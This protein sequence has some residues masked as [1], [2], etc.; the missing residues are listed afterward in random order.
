[1]DSSLPLPTC[2][3]KHSLMS[4]RIITEKKRKFGNFKLMTIS[5]FFSVLEFLVIVYPQKIE[6]NVYD[7]IKYD[8]T[9]TASKAA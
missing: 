1:M 7:I 4:V 9:Q 3:G 8:D 6:I 5:E 2:I